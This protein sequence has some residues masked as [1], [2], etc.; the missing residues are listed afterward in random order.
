[1]NLRTHLDEIY[2][3]FAFNEELLR[4]LYHQPKYMGDDPFSPEKA[5]MLTHPDIRDIRQMR[6]RFSP[7]TEG[8]VPEDPI[9]RVLFYPGNRRPTNNEKTKEQEIRFD[10][11]THLKFNDID[12]RMSWIM[13]KV[14]EIIKSTKFSAFGKVR[15]MPGRPFSGL[16]D[17]YIGYQMTYEFGD[18]SGR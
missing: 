13:D 3:A 8:L 4:L 18:F 14:D 6:I 12:M 16:P 7:T 1:M 10:V 15:E 2:M 11:V 9:C 5:E 17:N